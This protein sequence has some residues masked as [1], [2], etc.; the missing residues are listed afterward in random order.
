MPNSCSIPE[1]KSNYNVGDQVPIFKMPESPPDLKYAWTLHR[2]DTGDLKSVYECIKHFQKKGID[3]TKVPKGD[4]TFTE[5][6]RVNAEG[7]CS[8]STTCLSSLLLNG[9][10]CHTMKRKK[11]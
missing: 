5:V 4:G 1:C 11:I 2:E 8:K 10:A 7:T 9:L 3:T 6:S